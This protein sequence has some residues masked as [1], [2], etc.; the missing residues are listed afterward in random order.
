VQALQRV[1]VDTVVVH[2]G[3]GGSPGLEAAVGGAV[4]AGRLVSVARFTGPSAHVY[5]GT[6]DEVVRLVPVPREEAA[7]FPGGRRARDPAW[8]YSARSGD[9]RAAGD[10]DMSTAWLVPGELRAD[11]V[12]EIVFDRPLALAGVV[13]PLRRES[14][15]PTVLRIEGRS[16]EGEW[17][18]LARLDG[19]HVL[20]LVDQ[21]LVHPGEASL[22]FDL[23]GREASAVRLLMAEGARGFDGWVIP[24]V[25]VRVP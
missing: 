14:A 22:G 20:Q 1:G 6:A 24:E 12:L 25:E 8:R 11:D 17:G 3:R 13:L 19:P 16:A 10:G 23:T 9:P 18:R 2:H 5:E 4:A 15:F 7:P 21:L